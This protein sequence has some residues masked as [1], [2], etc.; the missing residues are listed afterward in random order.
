MLHLSWRDSEALHLI[1]APDQRPATRSV[2]FDH[3]W[4]SNR[5]ARYNFSNSQSPWQRHLNDNTN[6]LLRPCLPE[7]T[8]LNVRPPGHPLE[9]DNNRPE[10]SSRIVH[11]PTYSP[12]R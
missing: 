8:N 6:G 1:F 11:R 12:S 9:N 2:A 7:E 5:D 3:L 4:P 10:A